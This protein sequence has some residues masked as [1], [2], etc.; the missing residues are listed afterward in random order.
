MTSD[1]SNAAVR[2]WMS[3]V[4]VE[5]DPT[6][7]TRPRCLGRTMHRLSVSVGKGGSWWRVKGF[8]LAGLT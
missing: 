5:R 1:S 2:S 6:L 7:S 3:N 4:L 8:R